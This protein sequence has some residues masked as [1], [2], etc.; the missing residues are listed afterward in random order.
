M[1]PGRIHVAWPSGTCPGSIVIADRFS[2]LGEIK[3]EAGEN[4]AQGRC[5]I[6]SEFGAFFATATQVAGRP[7]EVRYEP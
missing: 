5:C 3:R 7:P 4:P 2:P 6:R 1:P